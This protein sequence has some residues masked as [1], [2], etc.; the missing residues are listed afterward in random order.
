MPDISMCINENCPVKLRCYRHTATPTE[1]R[2]AYM[3]FKWDD[4]GCD[5]FW[6]NEEPNGDGVQSAASGSTR[7]E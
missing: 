6:P 4:T 7:S 2:Q 3:F 5:H 1:Y